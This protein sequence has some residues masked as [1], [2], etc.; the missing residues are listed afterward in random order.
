MS[1][2]AVSSDGS[3]GQNNES[4]RQNCQRPGGNSHVSSSKASIEAGTMLRRRLLKIFQRDR[5]WVQAVGRQA[6]DSR[7]QPR[8][9]LP[10]TSYPRC[11]RPTS[12]E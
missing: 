3:H 5:R 4:R 8:S 7:Q 2:S 1:I 10:V 12:V 11:R 9:D 6:A